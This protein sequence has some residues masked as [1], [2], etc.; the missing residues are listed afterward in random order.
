MIPLVIPLNDSTR[1]CPLPRGLPAVVSSRA[2]WFRWVEHFEGEP[3][4]V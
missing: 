2:W 4:V 3:L 1:S